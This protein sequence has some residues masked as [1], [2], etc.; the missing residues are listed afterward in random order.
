MGTFSL[1]S[2]MKDA[3]QQKR[4]IFT[5]TT[6]RSGTGYLAH[7]L[8]CLPGV[9]SLLRAVQNNPDHAYAFWIEEKLPAIISTPHSIYIETSHLCCKGFLEPLMELGVTPDII[10]LS[11]PH[12][13]VALSHYHLN[14]IPGRTPLAQQFILNPNDPAVPPLPDWK[15]FSDYQLC[16]WYCLEIE[17]R[18]AQYRDLFRTTGS[19]VVD[20]S[21]QELTQTTGFQRLRTEL[22][23]PEPTIFGTIR[24]HRNKNLHI[25]TKTDLKS[26]SL[27]EED[28]DAQ[29]RAVSKAIHATL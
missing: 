29:E 19:R 20:I 16:Y 23:L 11:R 14:C 17:R 15:S 21:L 13:A 27:H 8:K 12:R 22:E 26:H 10:I 28:L 1:T 7:I 24:Y 5:V 4:L 25:N 2:S 3:L 18:A 6:G 9:T